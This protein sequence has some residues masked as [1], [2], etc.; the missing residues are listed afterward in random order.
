MTFLTDALG[1]I[2]AYMGMLYRP[3]TPNFCSKLQGK[4]AAIFENDDQKKPPV[5]LYDF[6]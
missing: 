1:V 2:L 3:K 5:S 4:E 6:L